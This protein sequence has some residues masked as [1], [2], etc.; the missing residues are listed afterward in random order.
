MIKVV[1]VSSDSNIGGAGK[2][3]LTFLKNFDREKFE[4]SVILPKNS[5]L[6][7]E[8]EKYN[9]KIYE[10]EHLAE[11]SLDFSAISVLKKLF[12]EIK[13]DIVHTHASMSARIAAKL[14]GIKTVYT[15]HSVFPPSP[16]IS[17]GL[18]KVINGYVNNHTAD[19]I[20]A[21]AEAAKD[22]LTDTGID[23]RKIEVILNGV[24]TL[25]PYK[26]EEIDRIKAEYNIKPEEKVAV[27][28][29]RLNVVKGHKYFVEAAKI[30][31]ERGVD[32]KFL[33]AGTGDVEEDLKA[34]IKAEGLEDRVLMLG[35]L[36]N[37]EPL[38]NIM[39]VQVNCSFG[40]EATSLAL[41][42]GMSL[43]KP[44]VVT[45]FGGNPGVIADGKNG[46]LTPTHDPAALADALEKLFCDDALYNKM[47]ED[48]KKI[49]SEKFTAEVNTRRIE[50]VY[51]RTLNRKG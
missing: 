13:P 18:G 27:M 28:A 42:E 4:V 8:A 39:D 44:A 38:M 2:C 29:A 19:S 35:F 49:Y 20:I 22:N 32:A 30:L 17:R 1:E 40:T 46:F 6:R 5:L 14:C 23:Q 11:K 16:K 48:C 24:E 21:V 10:A 25:V 9:V 45:D 31:K 15:R 3:I 43:G 7:P 41:L 33:I 26:K 34:Q 51:I 50:D 37:V 47:S 12:A 36:N